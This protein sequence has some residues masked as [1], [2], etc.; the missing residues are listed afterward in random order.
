MVHDLEGDGA[1]EAGVGGAV[2]RGHAAA[3]DLLVDAVPLVDES[4]DQRVG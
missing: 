3:R 4:P 1:V 2:D